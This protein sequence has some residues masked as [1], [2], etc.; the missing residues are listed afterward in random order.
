MKEKI[1]KTATDLFLNYGFKSVTMDDIAHK[2]AISKKTIY[3]HYANK[4]NLVEETT[5]HTFEAINNGIDAICEL[6]KN[7]IE[8][9]YEIKKFIMNHLKDEKASPQYQLQKFYPKIFATLRKK[10]FE[11][12]ISCVNE[13]L[14][15]G[16]SMELYRD[17]INI[18]FISILYF[19]NM[20]SLKDQELFSIKKF[21][22][23]S[24]MDYYLEYHLRGICTSKGLEK[25]NTI[26]DKK[27]LN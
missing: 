2:M 4:T 6:E 9:I 7:P 11:V 15:R 20:I 3:Q 22:I 12:M 24:L 8:E 10:Q 23:S 5:M 27:Q 21:S 13:N 19:H 25:L 16:L 14:T 18:D 26:I 17:S 1:L